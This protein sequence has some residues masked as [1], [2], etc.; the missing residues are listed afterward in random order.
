MS[1]TLY[2][3][4]PC[5]RFRVGVSG[6]RGPPKLPAESE[7][8]VRAVLDRIL[9][10]IGEEACKAESAYMACAPARSASHDRSATSR[11]AT[12]AADAISDFVVVSSVAEGA[13]RLVAE[14]G[15]AA[16]FTLEA[17][18]PFNRAEYGN[19]FETQAS[20]AAYEQLLRRTSA[21]FELDGN[22]DDRPRAY[23]TAGLIMLANI[24]LL[25]VIWDGNLA[26]GIGGTAQIVSRA[27]ADGIPIVWIEPTNPNATQISLPQA[28]DLPLANINARPQ[29]NFRAA[30]QAAIALA[31]TDILSL[32]RESGARL[33]L[34]RYL[35]EKERRWNFCPWYPL[36]VWLF[37]GRSPRQSDFRL[38]AALADT[39][40]Q[41]Q[42]Y[43]GILPKDRSQRPAIETMLLPAVSAA[44]HLA[45]YYS[46]V[47]RSTYVFNYLFAAV[48]VA[49]ALVGIFVHDATAK[50]YFV[51]TELV[52][53][54]II[55]VTW[56]RGH[57]GL[58]HQRWLEYRRLAEC[59]RHVRILA[60][61]GCK[62]PLGR[63]R[64]DLH[65][66]EQ[67]WV[68]WYAWSLRRLIPLPD[69]VVDAAYLAAVREAALSAEIDGQFSYH[70]SNAEAADKLD[71]RIHHAGQI[72][73]GTTAAACV[74]FLCLVWFVG[75]PKA[76]EEREL[77][78]G[79]F[80]F[81]TA[82]FPTLGAALGAIHVQGDFKTMVEQSRRT[83]K[84]LAAVGKV[85]AQ[86]PLNFARLADRIE[87]VSDILMAE[88]LEW[89]T[90]FRTRPLSLPA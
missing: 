85:L 6:H 29:D 23:E 41:W 39:K 22:V 2:P 33:S 68:S 78:L 35:T 63:P 49:L 25:I 66:Q 81:L 10:V 18:L 28:G 75:V 9:A 83:A 82:L 79:I 74:A 7:A 4:P 51:A 12:S 46:L 62:G 36:L 3:I 32:P 67:D 86:E 19:D 55:L 8:P 15:L 57:G 76:Q 21:V 43:L 1:S 44:D 11:D 42:G 26:A 77:V 16:G 24:D 27:I 64:R 87:K 90:I 45:I 5:I 70:T 60:P 17:V 53:I 56:L 13:D 65:A 73:F 84:R 69:A 72:V 61:L 48:A 40:A 31:I 52:I 89:Q 34:Q 71:G 14:A 58:R 30:D 88:L 37:A 54:V 47:Y 50:S 59:L 80:T 38:P 20:R